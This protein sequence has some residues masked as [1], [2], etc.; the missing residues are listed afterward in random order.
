MSGANLAILDT[1]IY[2]EN[3]RT[4]RFSRELQNLPFVVRCSAVVL[5]ELSRGA[6]SREMKE[7]VHDLVKNLNIVT[8][9]EREWS[10]SGH[11]VSRIAE[12][13]GF[14]VHKTREIHFDVLIALCARRIGAVLITLNATDFRT[15]L[16]YKKFNLDCW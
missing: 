15:I 12:D 16:E 5:A 2:I 11:L 14:D 9:S 10:E 13:K 6:R 8:P 7:F 1:S 3:L 4:G